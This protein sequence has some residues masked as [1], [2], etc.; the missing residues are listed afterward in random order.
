MLMWQITITLISVALFLVALVALRYGMSALV[1][2]DAKAELD[3]RDNVSFGLTI[4]GG[5][6][7]LMVIM[8]G[9]ISGEAEVSILSEILAVSGYAVMGVVLLKIGFWVQDKL[10]TAGVDLIEH[11]KQDNLAAAIVTT[12]N[13]VAIGLIVREAMYWVE[14]AGFTSVLPFALVFLASLIVLSGVTVLRSFIYARRHNNAKWSQAIADGNVAVAIRFAGQLISTALIMGATSALV[15]YGNFPVPDVFG[16][17]FLVSTGLMLIVWL[18]YR[19]CLVIVL[20]GID[21]VQ[22]VDNEQNA[23]V[24]CIEA[25]LFIG[26]AVAIVTFMA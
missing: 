25:A 7:A 24:A 11:I 17:W 21:V 14:G 10:L 9:A 2:V 19:L 1:G 6:L 22:E 23:G 4:A 8:S 3:N 15:T 18:V 12:A 5:T 20:H 26:I 16:A 13:L